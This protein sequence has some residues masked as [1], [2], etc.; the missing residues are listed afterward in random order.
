MK[1]TPNPSL[2]ITLLTKLF[3]SLFMKV[4]TN[5]QQAQPELFI[6]TNRKARNLTQ[7]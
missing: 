1:D 6:T 7:S 5:T 4:A 3:V 2:I